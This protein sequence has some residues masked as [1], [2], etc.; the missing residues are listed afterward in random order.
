MF[1]WKEYLTELLQTKRKIPP[2][3]R[4]EYQQAAKFHQQKVSKLYKKIQQAG[5][6][7][8]K[9]QGLI[10]RRRKQFQT[11]QKNRDQAMGQVR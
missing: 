11:Y 5:G 2:H 7:G 10:A 4:K 3:E 6:P 8:P 1:N 9:T